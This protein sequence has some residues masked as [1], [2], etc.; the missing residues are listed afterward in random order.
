MPSMPKKYEQMKTNGMRPPK[1]AEKPTP[2]MTKKKA[3]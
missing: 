1:K 3:K 2:K